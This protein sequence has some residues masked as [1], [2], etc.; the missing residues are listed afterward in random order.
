MFKP[1]DENSQNLTDLVTRRRQ[2]VEMQ[3]AEKN[4]LS[5]SPENGKKD[6]EEHIN[7]LQ[8]KIEQLNQ[9][10]EKLSQ[11]Q[12]LVA[13]QKI[14]LSAPGIGRATCAVCLAELPY[15]S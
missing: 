4:R 10:I 8:L 7:Y 2:L 6:L 12:H 1:L 13:K 15:Q 14:L 11:H 3:V 5:R 9:Q